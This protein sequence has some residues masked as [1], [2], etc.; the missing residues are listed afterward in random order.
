PYCYGLAIAGAEGVK[1][2]VE[3]LVAELT[4]AMKLLGRSSLK[5]LDSSVLWDRS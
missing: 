1:R 4:M 2:T 3:I 5:D